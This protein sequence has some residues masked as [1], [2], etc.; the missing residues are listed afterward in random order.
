MRRPSL[1]L[2]LCLALGLA[3]PA[4]AQSGVRSHSAPTGGPVRLNAGHLCPQC[5]AQLPKRIP[6]GTMTPAQAAALSQSVAACAGCSTAADSAPGIAW[7]GGH[8]VPGYA[9]VGL[10]ST[11][12]L[13]TTG[14][15]TPIGVMRTSYPHAAAPMVRPAAPAYIPPPPTP[16]AGPRVNKGRMLSHMLMVPLPRLDPFGRV[17]ARRRELHAAERYDQP[18]MGTAASLP[19]SMVYGRGR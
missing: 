16:I 13:A 6:A 18:V 15:P 2:G 7:V 9:T 14:E 3:L 10:E 8:E 19:A 1:T 5:A 12:T 11:A 17:A 4:A